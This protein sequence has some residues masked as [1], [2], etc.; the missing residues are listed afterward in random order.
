MADGLSKGKAL[1][2]CARFGD[3]LRIVPIR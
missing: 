2:T 1:S 3:T